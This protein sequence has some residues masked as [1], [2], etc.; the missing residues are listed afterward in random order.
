MDNA[1]GRTVFTC[2]DSAHA[3]I[4]LGKLLADLFWN[5]GQRKSELNVTIGK[6]AAV[7]HEFRPYGALVAFRAGR[8]VVVLGEPDAAT[9]QAIAA[10]D[11]SLQSGDAQ[12]TPTTPYPS[13]LDAY[14]LRNLRFHDIPMRSVN[15]APLQSHWDFEKKFGGGGMQY[16]APGFWSSCPAPGIIDWSSVDYGISQAKKNGSLVTLE[17]NAGGSFP[18][19]FYNSSPFCRATPSRSMLIDAWNGGGGGPAG[20]FYAGF[21]ATEAEKASGPLWFLRKVVE[22][23]RQDPNLVAWMPIAGFPGGE[24]GFHDRATRFYDYSLQGQEAFRRWLEHDRGMTLATLGVRWFGDE[25][26]FS[27]WSQVTLPDVNSFFGDPSAADSLKL[28]GNWQW[29]PAPRDAPSAQPGAQPPSLDNSHWVQFTTVPSQE[30]AL[31]PHGHAY[32]RKQFAVSASVAS[33]VKFLVVDAYV[34]STRPMTIWLNGAYLARQKLAPWAPAASQFEQFAVPVSG[35]L[36]AGP[37]ELLFD[38]PA[39]DGGNTEGRILGPVFFSPRNPAKY[40]NLGPYGN[41]RYAD[42]KDWQ[43][44]AYYLFNDGIFNQFRALDPNRPT[45]LSGDDFFHLGDYEGK[46]AMDYGLALQNTGREAFYSSRPSGHGIVVGFYNTSEESA[47]AASAANLD[48]ELG[49]ML[50]DADA[51]HVFY[52]RIDD[53]MKIEADTGWFSKRANLL[54][55]LGKAMRERPDVLLLLDP[56]TSRLGYNDPQ[57]EDLGA[58]TLEQM[59]LDH[60]YVTPWDL[61]NGLAVNYPVLFDC[62]TR[63][64]DQRLVDAI[65]RYVE[66]GGTF[67]ACADSGRSTVLEPDVWPI[68]QLTGFAV[69]STDE[70]GSVTFSGSLPI[71]APLSGVK[72]PS[73]DAAGISFE[74]AMAGVQTLATW[75]DGTTAVGY[76]QLGRGR[77]I[78]IGIHDLP[79]SGFSLTQAVPGRGVASQRIAAILLQSL[80]VEQT[81]FSASP[82]IWT[83]KLLAKNGLDDWLVAFNSDKTPACADVEIKVNTRPDRV[84]DV[85]TGANVGFSYTD[86][87]WVHIHSVSFEPDGTH[88]FGIRR[89]LLLDGVHVWWRE[90][91][92]YWQEKTRPT[93]RPTEAP[94]SGN[95][96]IKDW[97]AATDADR[98]VAADRKTRLP[99]FDDSQWR[100]L[101]TGPWKGLSPDMAQYRGDM[102]YRASFTIPPEWQG[103]EVDLNMYTSDTPIAF[104]D[105]QFEI[106]GQPVA[107]VSAGFGTSRTLNYDVTSRAQPGPHVLSVSV[108]HRPELDDVSGAF[109]SGNTWLSRAPRFVEQLDLNEKWDAIGDNW[110]STQPFTVPGKG[111]AKYI[112][113]IFSVAAEWKGKTVFIKIVAPIP[114]ATLVINGTL[115]NQNMYQHQMGSSMLLNLSPYIRAGKE[116]EIELWPVRSARNRYNASDSQ[117]GGFQIKRIQLG[118]IDPRDLPVKQ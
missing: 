4:L 3:D 76:R 14:D 38:I 79:K 74:S 7:I 40:P 41:A 115:I 102:F 80:G 104:G 73:V 28:D 33:Q 90:K 91:T 86:D 29:Q 44:Y 45:I 112:R 19:W 10:A 11:S 37:N 1:R 39:H 100:P 20:A 85:E 6:A 61:E 97:R 15:S 83:R 24:F 78:R 16:T 5:A 71:A 67:V 13:Y 26:H 47:T 66:D 103:R 69:R 51:A 27:N 42:L 30:A 63:V 52:F 111:E 118:V 92:R 53:N 46:L 70:K 75:R 65:A 88:V 62:G 18:L 93:S 89:G 12:F 117:H 82:G 43:C 81:S 23:Y 55:L 98:H 110:V 105:A 49:W 113:R 59:H 96:E 106:D 95:I 109:I 101:S 56:E 54:R 21:G 9:L 107:K 17:P 48:Q 50:F 87:G 32:N 34:H 64:M 25:R 84:T 77:I 94:S 60:G 116:N 72:F 114:F 31:L 35:K 68:N 108:A 2:Q 8:K 58:G 99:Q 36:K 22:R 57:H